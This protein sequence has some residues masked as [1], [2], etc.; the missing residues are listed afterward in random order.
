[1]PLYINTRGYPLMAVGVCQRCWRKRPLSALVP[2]GNTPGLRVCGDTGGGGGPRRGRGASNS[3]ACRDAYDPWRL[4]PHANEK[5][6][7]DYP[8]PD[9]ELSVPL[10]G[11]MV[12]GTSLDGMLGE[13][14]IGTFGGTQVGPLGSWP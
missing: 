11:T 7:L 4:P 3:R 14:Y 1:M 8:R 6:S 10:G 2:D 13:N 9:T 5:I 12:L